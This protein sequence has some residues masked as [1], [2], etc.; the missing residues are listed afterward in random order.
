[1]SQAESHELKLSTK[2]IKYRNTYSTVLS[3]FFFLSMH[4]IPEYPTITDAIVEL[5]NCES[6]NVPD[7]SLLN[8]K[9]TK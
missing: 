2:T 8:W 7:T 3:V 9:T 1:M 5:L 6:F 4:N